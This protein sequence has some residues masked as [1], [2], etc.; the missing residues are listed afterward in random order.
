MTPP[1][2]KRKS[3]I[4]D[5]TS[6]RHHKIVKKVVTFILDDETRFLLENAKRNAPTPQTNSKLIRWAIHV[7]YG[8][9]LNSVRKKLWYLQQKKDD[10]ERSM[11]HWQDV[12]EVLEEKGKESNR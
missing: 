11:Q 7:A 12:K 6:K 8:G 3:N 2:K 5:I 4:G 1:Q 9:M 10:V